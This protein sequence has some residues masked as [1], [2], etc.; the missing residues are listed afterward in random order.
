MRFADTWDNA[1][2]GNRLSAKDLVLMT[3]KNA[4]KVVALSDRIGELAPGRLADLFVVPKTGADP[5][6]SIVDARPKTVRLTMV[7]GRILYGDLPILPA[8]PA[9]PGCE[10]IDVCSATKFV[11]VAE[12]SANDKLSQTFAEIKAALEAAML[13]ADAQTPGDGY[14]FAPLA[15]LAK[16]N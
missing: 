3:T 7:G 4:A 13:A 12:A 16:C 1:N 14:S 9:L 10:T 8:A 5:W 15:P 11:C 6:Q 2:F